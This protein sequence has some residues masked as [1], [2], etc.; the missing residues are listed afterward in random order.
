MKISR[1][2]L[3]GACALAAPLAL[4]AVHADAAEA[5]PQQVVL[6]DI[7]GHPVALLTPL[8]AGTPVPNSIRPAAQTVLAMDPFAQMDAM[9]DAMMARMDRIAAMP[10]QAGAGG[11]MTID[12]PAGAGQ[13]FISTFSSG[14]HG[15]CSQTV[16]YRTDGSGQPKVDVR[17][18]GDACGALTVPGGRT[19]PAALPEPQPET[20]APPAVTPGQRIYNIDYRQPAKVKP[21]LHG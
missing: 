14:G 9:M 7:A 17:Q 15:S 2:L 5:S 3:L 1:A 20:L 13:V 18:T 16:T 19:V 4:A 11:P 21:A 8:T 6:Y 10:F 12:M